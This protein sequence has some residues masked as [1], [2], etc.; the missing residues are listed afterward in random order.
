MTDNAQ[1]ETSVFLSQFQSSTKTAQGLK[2]AQ[3]CWQQRD[4][5]KNKRAHKRGSLFDDPMIN[6]IMINWDQIQVRYNHTH[7]SK[8]SD[9]G[10]TYG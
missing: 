8:I 5:I 4:V 1:N 10:N 2:C 6:D 3:N 7:V 9:K